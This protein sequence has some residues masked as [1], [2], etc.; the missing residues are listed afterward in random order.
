V[1]RAGRCFVNLNEGPTVIVGTVVTTFTLCSVVSCDNFKFKCT[2]WLLRSSQY[3]L[4]TP[5]QLPCQPNPLVT[6]VALFR[7]QGVSDAVSRQIVL[8]F[9]V[10]FE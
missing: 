9:E 5:P 7:P 3:V 2:A 10:I 4:F 8:L 1:H 6:C